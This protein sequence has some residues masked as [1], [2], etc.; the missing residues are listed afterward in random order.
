[1]FDVGAFNDKYKV[2]GT[3]PDSTSMRE[4]VVLYGQ[5]YHV[6]P[7]NRNTPYHK[8]WD[9]EPDHDATLLTRFFG[10]QADIISIVFNSLSTIPSQTAKD[11]NLYH[12][13][14]EKLVKTPAGNI[15]DLRLDTHSET[16]QRPYYLYKKTCEDLYQHRCSHEQYPG[17]LDTN[18]TESEASFLKTM[19]Y[20]FVGVMTSTQISAS[21]LSAKIN[22]NIKGSQQEGSEDLLTAKINFH[23]DEISRAESCSQVAAALKKLSRNERIDARQYQA[24]ALYNGGY[25]DEQEDNNLRKAVGIA[26]SKVETSPPLNQIDDELKRR[27]DYFTEQSL[28]SFMSSIGNQ[29]AVISKQLQNNVNT[30][31]TKVLNLNIYLKIFINI[32]PH[33]PLLVHDGRIRYGAALPAE[34]QPHMMHDYSFSDILRGAC[35]RIPA[36]GLIVFDGTTYTRPASADGTTLF[37]LLHQAYQHDLDTLKKYATDLIQNIVIDINIKTADYLKEPTQKLANSIVE[38]LVGHAHSLKNYQQLFGHAQ[39]RELSNFVLNENLY[40]NSNQFSTALVEY[41]RS[42]AIEHLQKH[43]LFGDIEP[44]KLHIHAFV[45]LLVNNFSH[46]GDAIFKG[47]VKDAEKQLTQ[48]YRDAMQRAI[49]QIRIAHHDDLIL[50]IEYTIFFKDIYHKMFHHTESQGKDDLLFDIISA[51]AQNNN[52]DSNSIIFYEELASIIMN[53]VDNPYVAE[54]LTHVLPYPEVPER[55]DR[56]LIYLERLIPRATP[57]QLSDLQEKIL[58]L[59]MTQHPEVTCIHFGRFKPSV[60]LFSQLT[61]AHPHI[62]HL[63]L[64]NEV[65]TELGVNTQMS[66]ISAAHEGPTL[67][68]ITLSRAS[69]SRSPRKSISQHYAAVMDGEPVSADAAEALSVALHAQPFACTPEQYRALILKLQQGNDTDD[70]LF[71]LFSSYISVVTTVQDDLQQDVLLAHYTLIQSLFSIGKAHKARTLEIL[72]S[73][74]QLAHAYSM[75]T[76]QGLCA[77]LSND[78]FNTTYQEHIQPVNQEVVDSIYK[79][80][81]PQNLAQYTNCMLILINNDQTPTQPLRTDTHFVFF[82][83]ALGHYIKTYPGDAH[84]DQNVTLYINH[85]QTMTDTLDISHITNLL[86]ILNQLPE[87]KFKQIQN[88]IG[89]LL[90]ILPTLTNETPVNVKFQVN[91]LARKAVFCSATQLIYCFKL[92][93]QLSLAAPEEMFTLSDTQAALPAELEAISVYFNNKLQMDVSTSKLAVLKRD[94]GGYQRLTDQRQKLDDVVNLLEQLVDHDGEPAAQAEDYQSMIARYTP[95]TTKSKFN[96]YVLHRAEPSLGSLLT[97]VQYAKPTRDDVARLRTQLFEHY[98]VL[99]SLFVSRY[100]KDLSERMMYSSYE[101]TDLNSEINSISQLMNFIRSRLEA[102]CPTPE[103]EQIFFKKAVTVAALSKASP[104]TEFLKCLSPN[105]TRFTQAD[106]FKTQIELLE[107]QKRCLEK[108]SYSIN[109]S[110]QPTDPRASKN[111]SS[112]SSSNPSAPQNRKSI[113]PF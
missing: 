62:E 36:A 18:I 112:S 21:E 1:M 27:L 43:S 22:N 46:N 79:A 95:S 31:N 56:S 88:A 49:N 113:V 25:R 78:E 61:S 28:L 60:T 35:N 8:V 109:H 53:Y 66:G 12:Q 29:I 81:L 69:A 82:V 68:T 89:R 44:L 17:T 57:A 63:I 72:R 97:A 4:A 74:P 104:Y 54:F 90:N 48:A 37:T 52:R 38:L 93:P 98:N 34:N 67:T 45:Y 103:H 6:Y 19:S 84:F 59:F 83:Q 105:I 26:R 86:S 94:R 23:D 99:M 55:D 96:A 16:L 85:L 20:H 32:V 107:V 108:I 51:L 40:S 110:K 7:I 71:S 102:V 77:K 65:C 92:N 111:L 101:P 2:S 75:R 39:D 11:F 13:S 15:A 5:R 9:P 58:I 24:I 30:I 64:P 33:L 47:L 91:T 50:Y 100:I 3:T 76:L 87:A 10:F 80:G 73:S 42:S 70:A 41:I 106:M 14:L